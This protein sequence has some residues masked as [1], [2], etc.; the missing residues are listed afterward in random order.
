MS[1]SS[2]RCDS[3]AAAAAAA[4][5]AAAA[6]AAVKEE[7]REARAGDN[8]YLKQFTD[9]RTYELARISRVSTKRALP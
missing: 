6:V 1:R 2:N 7:A 9:V 3:S 5:V 4:A 8:A